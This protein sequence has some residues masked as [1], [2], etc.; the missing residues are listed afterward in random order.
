MTGTASTMREQD[1]DLLDRLGCCAFSNSISTSEPN[2]TPEDPHKGGYGPP[3]AWGRKRAP[4][5]AHSSHEC[6]IFWLVPSQAERPL[7]SGIL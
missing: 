5:K 7:S 1:Q 3:L 6:A 2:S 4:L